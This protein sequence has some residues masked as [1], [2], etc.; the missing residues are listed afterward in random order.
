M[1]YEQSI[2][3]K[4]HIIANL[5]RALQ[6]QVCTLGVIIDD[7]SSFYAHLQLPFSL[8][9]SLS[10]SRAHTNRKSM[11]IFNVPLVHGSYVMLVINV[12]PLHP[13]LPEDITI[14]R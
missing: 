7:A 1:T 13:H 14:T 3:R 4:D 12:N 11:L 9:L 5:T 10:L 2:A 6:K 8:C